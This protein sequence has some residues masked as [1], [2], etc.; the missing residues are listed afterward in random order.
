MAII[1]SGASTDQLS[2][3]PNKAAR[4]T[5]YDPQGKVI[6]QKKTYIC[7][8]NSWTI[9]ATP[10]DM[11]LISGSGS[12]TVKV[13]RVA[14]SHY[15]TTLGLNI[16]SL[17]K[18]SSADS[19]GTAVVDTAVPL[20]S[21]DPGASATVQHYTANPTLGGLVGN[22]VVDRVLTKS[23]TA[24]DGSNANPYVMFRADQNVAPIT[25]RG[26]GQQLA[27]NFGGAAL[28]AGLVIYPTIVWTEE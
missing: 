17:V 9:P 11:L 4:V 15:Q 22:V 8:P 23:L 16:F 21:N 13:L 2:V 18:R 3:D 10:T 27:L 28:P 12:T 25:L 19:G 5:I 6:G 1:K 26:T 20:D 24:V 7:S 14:F